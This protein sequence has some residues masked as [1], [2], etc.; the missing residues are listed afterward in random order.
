MT[1][2]STAFFSVLVTGLFAAFAYSK[3]KRSQPVVTVRDT[4]PGIMADINNYA[5]RTILEPQNQR[6][7]L[8]GGKTKR[9]AKNKKSRRI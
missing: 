9:K 7:T 6:R 1:N 4:S 8:L 3:Y 2:G 5:E